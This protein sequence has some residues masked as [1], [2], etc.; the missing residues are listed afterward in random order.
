MERIWVNS[1]H[2]FVEK[3]SNFFITVKFERKISYNHIYSSRWLMNFYKI[4]SQKSSKKIINYS[5]M[6]CHLIDW[7]SPS[8]LF[9]FL[10]IFTAISQLSH[11]CLLL[12]LSVWIFSLMF[13]V[14]SLLTL[15]TMTFNIRLRWVTLTLRR[16]DCF[17]CTSY[18]PFQPLFFTALHTHFVRIFLHFLECHDAEVLCCLS[19]WKIR[20]VDSD[21]D[22][23]MV[24]FILKSFC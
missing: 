23:L 6:S 19:E 13:Y 17:T 20:K 16:N 2:F 22:F 4:H 12:L 7:R 14:F 15:A 8:L 3:F 18:M 9:T 5:F 1:Q 10:I 11:V 24:I 21:D